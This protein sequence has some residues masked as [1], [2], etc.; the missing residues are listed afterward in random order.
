MQAA[1]PITKLV[2]VSIKRFAR[3][4]RANL[5]IVI[6]IPLVAKFGVVGIVA[7]CERALMHH[8]GKEVVHVCS[9]NV[10]ERIVRNTKDILWILQRLVHFALD[11]ACGKIAHVKFERVAD[12]VVDLAC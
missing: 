12:G 8:R 6:K 10:S 11:H 7:R 3:R 2:G 5:V 9:K 1:A 4:D